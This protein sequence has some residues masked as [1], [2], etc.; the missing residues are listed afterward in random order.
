VSQYSFGKPTQSCIASDDQFGTRSSK[1]AVDGK[2][3]WKRKAK[4][5][6]EKVLPDPTKQGGAFLMLISGRRGSGKTTL[7]CKLLL[8]AS[9]FRGKFDN[10][11]CISETFHLVKQWQCIDTSERDAYSDYNSTIIRRLINEQTS[12]SMWRLG[13]KRKSVLLLIDDIG[14]SSRL[15][16]TGQ[17]DYLDKIACNGRH[18]GVSIIF[19]QQQL[20]QT[21]PALRSNADIFI[22]FSSGSLRD[23]LLLFSEV[24]AGPYKDFR[25]SVEEI[26]AERYSFLLVNTNGERLAYH[27]CFDEIDMGKINKRNE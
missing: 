25:N 24:G 22:Q 9:A 5:Q 17:V 16:K 27:Q 15:T 6:L 12:S 1:E 26:T 10:I 3:K 18:L 14:N 4:S 7:A 8:T 20:T 13:R 19:L 23:N 21:S 11:I 2:T